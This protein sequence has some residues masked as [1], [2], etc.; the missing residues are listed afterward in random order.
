MIERALTGLHSVTGE[1]PS[2]PS[3]QWTLLGWKRPLLGLLIVPF[4]PFLA[5]GGHDM[6]TA[7]DIGTAIMQG[8]GQGYVDT[9]YLTG[10]L[11]VI[12]PLLTVL[13]LSIWRRRGEGQS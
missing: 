3:S 2:I 5:W 8:K 9:V 4:A 6:V 11:G 10:A 7:A 1:G 13:A 12:G